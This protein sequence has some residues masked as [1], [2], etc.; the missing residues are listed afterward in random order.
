MIEQG[1]SVV[2][3]KNPDMRRKIHVG[4]IS[5]EGYM[6]AMSYVFYKASKALAKFGWAYSFGDKD[7]P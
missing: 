1:A 4:Y 3:N 5:E 6:P 7:Q 2:E